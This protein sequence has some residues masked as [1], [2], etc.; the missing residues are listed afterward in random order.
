MNIIYIEYPLPY[1][2]LMDNH[3]KLLVAEY[4]G[5]I[6]GSGAGLGF[7]DLEIKFTTTKD[8]NGFKTRLPDIVN[9]CK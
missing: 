6:Q 1:Y 3:I 9:I 2:P 5:E 7:R 8:L 4:C